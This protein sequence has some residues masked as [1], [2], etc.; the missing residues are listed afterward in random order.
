MRFATMPPA[1][2]LGAILAHAVTAPGLAFKKGRRLYGRRPEPARRG[3]GRLG[4]RGP[5]RAGGCR[6]GRGRRPAWHRPWR[7]RACASTMPSPAGSICTPRRTAFVW[8][9]PRST[10]GEPG[11]RDGHRGDPARCRGRDARQDAG[12][13]EDHPLRRP[14]GGPGRCLGSRRAVPG[15]RRPFRPWRAA[16]PDRAARH[17]GEGPRQDRSGDAASGS[18]ARRHARRRGALPARRRGLGRG[19]SRA[20]PGRYDLSRR[21]RLGHHRPARRDAGRRS[22]PRAA[23]SSISACRS[24][25]ATCCCWRAR[26]PARAGP[27]RLRPLAQAQRLRLGAAAARR[28]A[29]GDAAATS[30]AWASAACSRRSRAGRSRASSRATPPAPRD[31]RRGARRRPIDAHGRAQQA[32]D[33]AGRR[34]DGRAMSWRRHWRA[35]PTEVVVVT[36]H[37][38]ERVEAALAGRSRSASCTTP[39]MPTGSAPR[40]RPASA[41]CPPTSM[42]PSSASATCRR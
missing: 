1:D 40:S 12:D 27:A 26:R 32:A 22:R 42:A 15:P 7:A 18:G 35:R 33:R 21:R 13:G 3:R 17:R 37:E 9:R 16:G 11:G 6:R 2:A 5:A 31:R 41:P 20:A 14:A 8:S 24:I 36:G 29:R 30:W 25:P 23:W 38:R 19:R 4:Y 39:T 34:A 10:S 28:R